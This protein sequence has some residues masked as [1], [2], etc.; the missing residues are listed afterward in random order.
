MKK[1]IKVRVK[2]PILGGDVPA[3]GT[4]GQVLQKHSDVD[5][6][7][8]WGDVPTPEGVE[9]EENK[10]QEIDSESTETE[11]PSAKAV[12][13]YAQPKE[14]GKGLSE[15]DYSDEEKQKVASAVTSDAL[16]AALANKQDNLTAQQLANIA[17]VPNKADASDL[18]DY[19]SI[20]GIGTAVVGFDPDTPYQKGRMVLHRDQTDGKLKV[21][22]FTDYHPAGAWTGTDVKIANIYNLFANYAGTDTE[23]V[24][25]QLASSDGLL[26]LSGIE[27]TA[28][29]ADGGIETKEADANGRCVFNVTKGRV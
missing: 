8:I 22:E 9:M 16:A 23:K 15:N 7:T 5:N 26:T 17:D 14:E 12:Y 29:Y 3:G 20:I 19:D 6:D 24:Y 13:D 4:T 1:E 2:T 18:A 10:V 25:V 21:Y 27:V 28:N 11:Y